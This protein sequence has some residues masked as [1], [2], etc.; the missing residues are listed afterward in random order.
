MNAIK[1]TTAFGA[2]FLAC[3]MLLA[4]FTPVNAWFGRKEAPAAAA[5]SKSDVTG[6]LIT[7]SQEDFTGRVTGKEELSAIVVSALPEGGVLRLAGQTVRQGEAIPTEQ[8]AALCFVPEAGQEIH[9]SFSFFPVFSRSG[10]GD[11]SVTVSLNVSDT[12]NACPIAVQQSF[13]TYADLPLNGA[14]KAVDPDGDPCTFTVIS[15]GK[16]GTAEIT[17]AGFRYTPSGSWGKDSFTVEAVDCYGNRSQPA[18]ITVKVV[19]RAARETFTYTDLADSPVHYAALRLREAGVF[20]GESFG[21]ESFFHPEQPVSRAEFLAMT[22]SIAQL[23]QPVSAVST[24][25]SDNAAIPA[26]AQGYVAAGILSGVVNGSDD[27]SGN[28]EFRA[29]IPITRAEAAAILDRCLS[30]ADDGRSMAFADREEV[31][32]WAAQSVVN[33]SAAGLLPVFSDN[34]IRSQAAVTRQDAAVMLYEMMQYSANGKK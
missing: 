27:G 2:I 11:Q 22:A 19:K 18:E 9:T 3:G 17:E 30:L 8:L 4:A 10:A 32:A 12:P 1:K 5:F 14:L 31:P 29:D 33:T 23:A 34:T 26:W 6:Q 13:E 28:R 25:L 21:S 20:S 7:F 24:G 15:Q 16:R